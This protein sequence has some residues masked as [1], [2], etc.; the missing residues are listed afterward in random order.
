MPKQYRPPPR[1]KLNELIALRKAKYPGMT[2]KDFGAKLGITRL[3]V[4]T[5]EHGRRAASMEL[6]LRWL[7]LLAPEAR[8]S[9]FGPLPIVEER[10]TLIKALRKVSPQAA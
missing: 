4:G 3:H 2:Q 1:P 10:L 7:L 5:I 8:L 6:A 9:M